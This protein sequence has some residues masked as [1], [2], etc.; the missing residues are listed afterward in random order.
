[1][2]RA[3][4]RH[5]LTGPIPSCPVPFHED[6]AIDYDGL[7][8]FIDFVIDADARTILLTYGDSLFSLLTDDEVADVTRA[9]VEHT[10]GRAMV[11]AADRQWATP[12][13]LEFR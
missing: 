1:M 5:H 7:R 12:K 6:G 9:V 3:E 10:A 8:N 4:A 2:D 13:A 11:V